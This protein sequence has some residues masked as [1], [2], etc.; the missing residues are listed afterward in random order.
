[1]LKRIGLAEAAV[2]ASHPATEERALGENVGHKPP[3]PT[4]AEGPELGLDTLAAP[5]LLRPFSALDKRENATP[6]E[7]ASAIPVP[8]ASPKPVN[9][10]DFGSS[11]SSYPSEGIRS[12]EPGN[13]PP[14]T[15]RNRLFSSIGRYSKANHRL[16]ELFSSQLF[17]SGSSTKAEVDSDEGEPMKFEKWLEQKSRTVAND[18]KMANPKTLA[19]EV[20]IPK[21]DE[22]KA[23]EPKADEPK[24]HDATQAEDPAVQYYPIQTNQVASASTDTVVRSSSDLA[25]VVQRDGPSNPPEV[26]VKPASVPTGSTTDEGIIT[27]SKPP[28]SRYVRNKSHWVST[29]SEAAPLIDVTPAGDPVPAVGPTPDSGTHG[30]KPS[31]KRRLGKSKFKKW[32]S[33]RF[34]RVMHNGE[35]GVVVQRAATTSQLRLT[36]S[37]LKR[38]QKGLGVRKTRRPRKDP[39]ARKLRKKD[40]EFVKYRIM[41]IL[42]ED[43]ELMA[44]GKSDTFTRKMGRKAKAWAR[45]QKGSVK[46]S[47]FLLSEMKRELK[48]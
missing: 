5:F 34:R 12:P 41:N 10:R 39:R 20:V 11:S 32:L 45:E 23:D 2:N 25:E 7:K 15:V 48:S 1:M 24:T 26:T 38:V 28:R 21:A 17:S 3:V 16:S 47:G 36:T 6:K 8:V 33:K 27:T 9:R 18:S 14:G 44:M 13:S 29:D 40:D 19:A 42:R 22:P 4:P 43:K 30:Q 31:L 35:K 37:N 46:L